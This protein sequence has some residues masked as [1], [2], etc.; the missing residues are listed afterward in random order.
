MLAEDVV[1]ERDIVSIWYIAGSIKVNTIQY[2][3]L[4]RPREHLQARPLWKCERRKMRATSLLVVAHLCGYLISQQR[5]VP[6]TTTGDLVL[7]K[8]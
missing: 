4:G 1:P 7:C 6:K 2:Q 5:S 3:H 8:S